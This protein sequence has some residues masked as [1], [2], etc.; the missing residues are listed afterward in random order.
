VTSTQVDIT[1]DDAEMGKPFEKWLP[2]Q[3]SPTKKEEV[4]GDVHVFIVHGFPE[5]LPSNA[6]YY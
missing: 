4:K 3:V 5:V 2:L 1:L 6:T